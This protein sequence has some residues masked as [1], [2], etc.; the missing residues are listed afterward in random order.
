MARPRQAAIAGV[1]TTKQG[2]LP[3][4]TSFSLQLEA[5]K[6]ACDDA[7]IPVEEVDGIIPL[8]MSDHLPGTTATQFWAAQLGERPLGLMETGGASGALAKAAL[9]IENGMCEVVV[10]FYGKAGSLV[11]PRGTAAADKAPRVPDWSFYQSGAYMTTWYALWAQ[12]YMHEFGATHADL[13]EVAVF[14]RYHATLNPNSIMGRKGEI[15]VEDVLN[16]RPICEPLNLLDCSLDNDGGYAIVMTS[17][18]R[19][20][21]AKSKPVWVLGGAESTYT[22]FYTTINDPWFPE[23]G[24][25][26]RRAAN[27]AFDISGIGRDEIDVA[28]LYDCF[29]ITTIRDLEEMGFCKLGEGAEYVKEGHCRLGGSMPTNT[30]GGLLSNSHAGDPAGMHTIEVVRQLRGECGERQ[31]PNAKIGV[32]LQ[33]GWAVHGMAGVLVMAAD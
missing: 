15:T 6:G 26:V 33:Q 5:I 17:A 7:G 12:R 14:T 18:E 32:S 8:S 13:A 27:R 1:Y 16:S 23:E 29:T 21:S 10:L 9:A 2:K 11:G 20:R 31:V 28:G 22:D 25:A 3:D 19:A 30:D 4:R 24:K